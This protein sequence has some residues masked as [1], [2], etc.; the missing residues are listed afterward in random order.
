MRLAA[1][2]V[3]VALVAPACGRAGPGS[4]GR[5]TDVPPPQGLEKAC[6]AWDA[7]IR[8]AGGDLPDGASSVRLCPGPPI[9]AQD[10]T[11]HDVGIQAP[12]LL[13]TRV[14]EV[15]DAV[16]DLGP[17]PDEVACPADGGSRLTYWFSYPDGD[18]RA[19]TFENFGC[20]HLLVG[21]DMQR[22]DGNRVAQV[23]TEALLSQRSA[24][25]PPQVPAKAPDCR[26]VHAR[27]GT[28]LP[29]QPV[30]LAAASFCVEA[31]SYRVRAAEV[32]PALLGELNQGLAADAMGWDECR[33]PPR[34]SAVLLG[35]TRWGDLVR[36]LIDGCGRVLVPPTPGWLRRDAP[37]YRL[38][39]EL[40]AQLDE[41]RLGPVV[42]YTSPTSRTTPP[43]TPG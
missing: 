40:S 37:A 41:L 5:P 4:G 25:S 7:P 36:Y 35:H 43:A 24:M 17:V 9:V 39:P 34:R 21:Q 30:D 1:A 15:V 11:I 14:D 2:L 18:A 23:H 12:E 26:G 27:P 10:G 8:Y 42:R 20:E 6:P 32:P 31:G 13:T 38:P 22:A 16:N 19:V 3:L 28:V 33:E 29:H